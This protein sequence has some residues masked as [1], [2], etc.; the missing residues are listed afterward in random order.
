MQYDQNLTRDEILGFWSYWGK[1]EMA[2]DDIII[3]FAADGYGYLRTDP[4]EGNG[5]A[6]TEEFTWAYSGGGVWISSWSQQ[7]YRISSPDESGERILYGAHPTNL[8][9]TNLPKFIRIP[10]V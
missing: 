10:G 5:S 6:T 1:Q 4:G 2:T 9:D 7:V 3:M 8:E